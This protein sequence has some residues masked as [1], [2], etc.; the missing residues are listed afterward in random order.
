MKF[1]RK[2][3]ALWGSLAL[4]LSNIL[5][6]QPLAVRAEAS[7]NIFFTVDYLIEAVVP[8]N[9]NCSADGYQLKIVMEGI[10]TPNHLGELPGVTIV[11]DLAVDLGPGA[12]WTEKPLGTHVYSATV[13]LDKLMTDINTTMVIPHLVTN[14]PH[15]TDFTGERM[16]MNEDGTVE[17]APVNLDPADLINTFNLFVIAAGGMK[18]I[19]PGDYLSKFHLFVNNDG[20]RRVEQRVWWGDRRVPDLAIE[21]D[22]EGVFLSEVPAD[23]DVTYAPLWADD[24][25]TNGD[26][27]VKLGPGQ[28][29]KRRQSAP[30]PFIEKIPL[31]TTHP[32]TQPIQG[33]VQLDVTQRRSAPQLEPLTVAPPQI[34]AAPNEISASKNVAAKA[35]TY[36]LE[37]NMPPVPFEKQWKIPTW[38]PPPLK[39]KDTT[40][41]AQLKL[42]DEY[43]STAAPTT[44]ITKL[45][46]E[47]ELE[48]GKYAG[49][50]G[51]D[52][53]AS[54]DYKSSGLLFRNGQGKAD[55][56]IG[57]K[58][59]VG[60]FDLVPT[61]K[62]IAAAVSLDSWLEQYAKVEAGIFIFGNGDVTIEQAA[63]GLDWKAVVMTGVRPIIKYQLG[64]DNGSVR[65]EL[66]AKGEGRIKFH[67]NM[68]GDLFQGAEGELTFTG[69]LTVLHCKWSKE[70][71]YTLSSAQLF[72]ND[73]AYV[74]TGS[75]ICGEERS[76]NGAQGE[77]WLAAVDQQGVYAAQQNQIERTLPMSSILVA[78]TLNTADPALSP[79][80]STLCWV[81][82]RVEAPVGRA[83]EIVCANGDLPAFAAPLP[84]TQDTFADA[85]PRVAMAAPNV[86]L[87]AWWRHDDPN[88]PLTVDLDAT[89]LQHGEVMAALF[90]PETAQ[91]RAS[92][93]LGT[94]GVLDYAPVVAGNGT[95]GALVAWRTNTAGEL[96][97][98]GT[99]PD[100]LLVSLYDPATQSWRNAETLLTTRGLIEVAAAYGKDEAAL[101]YLVDE[102]GVATTT[103][104]VELYAR[105]FLN[106]SWQPPLRLTTNNHVEHSPK[107]A[108]RSDG[109]PFLLWLQVDETGQ[110]SMVHQVAWAG[111]AVVTPMGGEGAP[112][113]LDSMA[114][115]A[116]GDV[117]LLWRNLYGL[118]R[119]SAQSDLTFALYQRASG[120][121]S[122]PLRLTNDGAQEHALSIVWGQA[123]DLYALFQARAEDGD[124]A[125]RFLQQPLDIA[126]AA[127]AAEH[128]TLSPTNPL[129]GEPVTVTVAIDNLGMMAQEAVTVQLH[130]MTLTTPT[131]SR[132]IH[133]AQ[134]E[135]IRGGETIALTVPYQ[136]ATE[137]SQL[138]LLISCPG[139]ACGAL[140]NDQATIA[141][142]QPNLVLTGADVIQGSGTPRVRAH[143]TNQGVVGTGMVAMS[144]TAALAEGNTL[145]GTTFFKMNGEEGLQPGASAVGEF[146]L[147]L[148]DID[149][150]G[151]AIPLT[152]TVA[153]AFGQPELTVVDN[154]KE[155]L[156][157]RLPDLTLDSDFVAL[158]SQ[159]TSTT[160]QITV[161]N[162]SYLDA[163]P[164]RVAAYSASP[165]EDGVLLT[166]VAVPAIAAYSQ[167]T[168]TLTVASEVHSLWLRVNADN[169]FAELTHAN[170]DAVATRFIEPDDSA[171]AHRVW[172]PLVSR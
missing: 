6:S 154:S 157:L 58:E 59:T 25:N 37:R 144:V 56:Q 30:Q 134:I 7:N 117:L 27:W 14:V 63:N 87:V 80:G 26:V 158:Q 3:V 36:K 84:V 46:F 112:A 74:A 147:P 168:V 22:V 12:W 54:F 128:V 53:T 78:Q 67:L 60:P 171:P 92:H 28:W 47:G 123:G 98:F 143:V 161:F 107:I 141:V 21:P 82:Q 133:E 116:Q 127:V 148:T 96:N 89:F 139:G 32:T 164:S 153:P 109:T 170:N 119:G 15:T 9:Q 146:V 18:E 68:P 19:T 34:V 114:M 166:S 33:W 124:N 4:L 61:I 65:L 8:D 64:K 113:W 111:Q 55:L 50:L 77:R 11:A 106:G 118:E 129:P 122:A 101:L 172:L 138:Q 159:D 31:G 41:K 102:D 69:A 86:P 43:E 100:D 23:V 115:N 145:L 169:A 48:I 97:G 17:R 1:F 91:W 38:F 93:Q 75:G 131:T 162:D 165:E 105:R 40:I 73:A 70:A 103:N 95:D 149:I 85:A 52:G 13:R 151:D 29:I 24:I 57:I 10:G 49:K 72:A 110:P 99:T 94:A 108:Y 5:V 44:H 66:E 130:E 35:I 83:S 160:A 126:D 137:A 167:A 79:D 45:G 132:L 88:R 120:R 39:G 142:S 90:D 135:H 71:K 125:I 81:T 51:I 155:V 104:D 2:I 152:V 20:A 62:P 136:P 16:C 76:A 140:E 121:W 150:D 42:G 163:P 156:W